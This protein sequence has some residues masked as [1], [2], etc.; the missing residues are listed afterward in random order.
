M[1]PLEHRL[2]EGLR[3]DRWR[4][5]P[6]PDVLDRVHAGVERRRRRRAVVATAGAAVV[7]VAAGI[8]GLGYVMNG[9]GASQTFSSAGGAEGDA[10]KEAA[11]DSGK[12]LETPTP[13]SAPRVG[14]GAGETERGPSKPQG[15]KASGPQAPLRVAELPKIPPTFS[16][17][18]LTA[19]SANTFWVLGSSG[20]GESATASVA[21]TDDGGGTFGKVATLDATAVRGDNET[22]PDT[23]RDLRFAGDGRNGWAYGGG[24][25][26]TH[27]AGRSWTRVPTLPGQVDLLEAGGSAAYALARDGDT[28]TLW[29]TPVESDAWQRLD[30]TPS[31]PQGLAVT[32]RLVALTDKAPDSTVVSV[33]TDGGATFSQHPTPCERDLEPGRLSATSDALWLTCATGTAATVS[34][35]TDSGTTWAKVPSGEPAISATDSALG[36]RSASKA[37]VASRGEALVLGRDSSTTTPV[38]GLAEPAYAGFT[39]DR[40]GYI[41]DLEGQLFRTTDGGAAWAKVAVR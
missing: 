8:G 21:M 18:S 34:V 38:P 7:L 14:S 27:D 22:G 35:S 33:S 15:H 30:V 17:I 3:D 25:W 13:E 41:L 26:A 37:V 39:T 10:P 19:A 28:W 24:L 12:T 5:P 4:L 9:F 32:S 36:A 23:V 29:R 40:V 16:T 1:D 31:D 2:R 20:S 11:Q 6:D